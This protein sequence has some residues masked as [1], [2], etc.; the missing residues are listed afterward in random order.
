MRNGIYVLG[1]ADGH[2]RTGDELGRAG[3]SSHARVCRRPEPS[4]RTTARALGLISG[5]GSPSPGTSPYAGLRRGSTGSKVKEVQQALMRT[6]LVLLGG[7]DGIFG[8]A[9]ESALKLFQKVNG[10][11]I[12]GVVDD[13]TAG[14]TGSRRRF[15][16][17]VSR[18]L[19][20]R[21]TASGAPA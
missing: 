2:L 14:C 4:I 8:P 11:R 13:A 17:P 7:A 9:T 19:A 15:R 3:S 5:G 10:L 6:G 18:R 1:G 21:R 12:T 16:S 20:T